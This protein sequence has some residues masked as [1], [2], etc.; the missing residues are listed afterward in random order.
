[1]IGSSPK[2]RVMG[3][4]SVSEELERS[5]DEVLVELEHPAVPGVGIEDELTVRESSVEVDGVLRGHHPVA[6][7]VDDEHRLLDAHEV[8][9][10]L[11]A[12][13]PDGFVLGAK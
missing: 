1:M 11:A 4:G 13:S 12:P 2:V 7:A 8:S 5:L 6:L 10:C 9:G 3:R